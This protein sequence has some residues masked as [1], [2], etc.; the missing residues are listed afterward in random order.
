M[1]VLPIGPLAAGFLAGLGIAL[2]LGA[3]GVLIV[4]EGVERGLR[5]A[6][7]AA[8]AVACVDLAYALVAVV[9]GVR[10]AETLAGWE[11]TIQLVGAAA[12]AIVV[13]WGVRGTLR[14][15][16]REHPDAPATPALPTHHVFLRFVGL[17]A[18][19]PMTAVYFAALTTGLSAQLTGPAGAAFAAGV[20]LGSATWQLVLAFAGAFAGGRVGP[21]ARVAI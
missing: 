12:L 11:R 17:T 21:G 20:F 6:V 16:G 15:V 14:G 10:V 5:A 8:V 4:R 7:P 18:V 9:L 19:N 1:P 2:P 3:I 13:V